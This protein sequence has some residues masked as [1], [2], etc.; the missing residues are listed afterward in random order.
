MKKPKIPKS[1]K[2]LNPRAKKEVAPERSAELPRITNETVA[3]HREEVLSSA[4]KYIYPL[5]HSRH[6]I[7]VVSVTIFII[8]MMAF[9]T[10]TVLA[11]YR[12]HATSTFMYRIT[13][14]VPFP[15]AKAGSRFVTYD[16]YLFELR[17]YI[18]YYESQ[19]KVNFSDANGQKLLQEFRR[20]ALDNVI[21][22]AYVKQIA[23]EHGLSV[24]RSEVDAQMNLLR[25]QNRLGASNEVLEDVLKKFWGWSID[26]FRSVLKQEL[27][28]QKVATT[29]DTG[30]H[31]RA[32]AVLAQLRAG[33][34]FAALAGQH[35]DEL[36][37][38]AQGGAYGVDIVRTNRDIQPRVMDELYKLNV[39]QM[40]GVIETVTGLEI[41]KVTGKTPD[42]KV[43][44]SH[45]YFK[46][47][48]V[49]EY[50]KELQKQQKT[51]RFIST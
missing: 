23:E 8:V 4:R 45:I 16:D 25:S 11:L 12:F 49:S 28:A 35:S 27:L 46:V 33:G 38:K 10:Y 21:Q 7:V 17:R 19:Q 40:S 26:D 29:L 37:T 5:Q 36:Q 30:A 1:I 3:E 15:V 20:R 44:A 14:V 22:D 9:V 51:W 47:K 2:K 18:H 6:R 34:D 48:P 41:V 32:N 24:S 39:G 50:V 13:Q 31:D 42:G 43:Q